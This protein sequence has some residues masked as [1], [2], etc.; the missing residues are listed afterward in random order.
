MAIKCALVLNLSGLE[1]CETT[2]HHADLTIG[3]I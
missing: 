1:T 3:F 2:V